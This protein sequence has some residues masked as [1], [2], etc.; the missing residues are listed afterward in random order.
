MSNNDN[1][2]LNDPSVLLRNGNYYKIVPNSNMSTN[3]FLN[4]ITLIFVYLAILYI[5]FTTDY[6]YI[7]VIIIIVILL[8]ALYISSAKT[9]EKFGDTGLEIE[10]PVQTKNVKYDPEMFDYDD[11]HTNEVMMDDQDTQVPISDQTEFAKWAYEAPETCKENSRNC[12]KYE[13]IRFNRYNPAHDSPSIDYSD[14]Q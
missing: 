8:V 4:A 6:G 7:Y 3:Q 2:W 10:R 13:D 12:L 11:D 14:F 5:L 9:K 1:F